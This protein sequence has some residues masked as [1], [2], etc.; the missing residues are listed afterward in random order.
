M[1]EALSV[2]VVEG[3][4]GVQ[5]IQ[6]RMPFRFGVVTI[7]AAAQATL[8]L[9]VAFSDGGQV[10]GYAADFL[11]YKWF[12]K[13]PER[14]PEQ[15]SQDLIRSINDAISAYKDAG[16]ATAFAHWRDLHPGL[17]RKSLERGYNQLGGNFGVSMVERAMIDAVGRHA[18]Q[19]F[20]DLMRGSLLGLEEASVF[21]ELGAGAVTASLPAKPLNRVS[22]RHT[23]GLVDPIFDTDIAVA[24]R[25]NDG[26]PETLE[27]YLRE[28]GIHFLKVK[29]SGDTKT[30]IPRL[31][32]IWKAVERHGQDVALTLDGNEQ[33]SSIEAFAGLMDVVRSTPALARFYNAVQFV[34]Q[35][36]ERDAALA[37]P[38]DKR[39]LEIIGKPLIIDEAD[40]W[41]TAFKEAVACGYRGV[42]HKNCKGI[43]RSFLNN[44]LASKWNADAGANDFFL[45]AEDLSD[46]P[47]VSLQS[48]LAAVASLG[49]GHVERNGH[50]YFRGLDH[51]S[52]DEQKAAL[53]HHGDLYRQD[54]GTTTLKIDRGQIDIGSLQTPGFGF[55]TPPDM[56]RMIPAEAWTFSMLEDGGTK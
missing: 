31:Q 11:S 56:D 24:D 23:I 4:L 34:E 19:S 12:D 29:V 49:I 33:Y 40:G 47:L 46:M 2:R 54:R 37:G 17:E 20:D 3:R 22:L 50:H 52:S 30:D 27:D 8:A 13:R 10:T 36:V 55:A 48:D 7:H 14:T 44:A 25:I 32:R 38:L 26:L 16:F 51:L 41:T 21:P 15:G 6:A 35:P 18:G 53:A 1:S 43:F 45:S 9:E 39:A 5:N 42:S 28:D